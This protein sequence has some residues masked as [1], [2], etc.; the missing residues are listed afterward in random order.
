MP[1]TVNDSFHTLARKIP[2]LVLGEF[3]VCTVQV[4]R[5]FPAFHYLRV[6]FRVCLTGTAGRPLFRP[7]LVGVG[8]SSCG[9]A[10]VTFCPRVIR[11]DWSWV[12][13]AFTATLSS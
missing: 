8:R 3:L 13:L 4:F 12:R 5:R 2:R 10:C 6:G 9:L 7:P 1:I 11:V